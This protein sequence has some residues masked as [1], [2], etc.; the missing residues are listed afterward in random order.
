MGWRGSRAAL[1]NRGAAYAT[2]GNFILPATRP[3]LD[4][5]DGPRWAW[6]LQSKLVAVNALEPQTQQQRGVNSRG[7]Y[8]GLILPMLQVERP[9]K[10]S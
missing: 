6:G 2:A 3:L 1:L 4:E 10:R 7:T 8:R 9:R 5:R